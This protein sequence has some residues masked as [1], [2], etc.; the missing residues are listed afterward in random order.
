MA[1]LQQ[2]NSLKIK[3]PPAVISSGVLQNFY[4]KTFGTFQRA[5]PRSPFFWCPVLQLLSHQMFYQKTWFQWGPHHPNQHYS[6][7]KIISLLSLHPKL[8]KAFQARLDHV[9]IPC[10]LE[11]KLS[12]IAY[13]RARVSMIILQ[14]D[15]LKYPKWC[16]LCWY[17]DFCILLPFLWNKP[18]AATFC[19]KLLLCSSILALPSQK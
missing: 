11:K 8:L 14:R 9:I 7:W 3:Q 19:K 6:H 13:W 10:R 18:I 15:L 1:R 12:D 16:M 5:L 4:Q 2:N 17:E